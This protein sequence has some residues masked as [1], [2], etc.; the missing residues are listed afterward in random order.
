MSIYLYSMEYD[1]ESVFCHDMES[2]FYQLALEEEYKQHQ[3]MLCLPDEICI[4]VFSYCDL[5]EIEEEQLFA[6]FMKQCTMFKTICVRFSKILTHTVI[7]DLY[8]GYSLASKNKALQKIT[9]TILQSNYETKIPGVLILLRS[10]ASADVGMYTK[11]RDAIEIKYS[12]FS[13][14]HKAL[15]YKALIQKN[16]PLLKLLL[17]YGANPNQL[18]PDKQPLFFLSPTIDII[19]LFFKKGADLN[20]KD[21]HGNNVLWHVQQLPLELVQFY[22]DHKVDTRYINPSNKTCILH[23]LAPSVKYINNSNDLFK[24][25]VLLIKTIPDM[26]N[27]LDAEGRTPIDLMEKKLEMEF[28]NNNPRYPFKRLIDFYRISGGKNA[29]ELST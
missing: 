14:L 12:N 9:R 27:T 25:G 4:H 21:K 22:I 24:K 17:D 19:N 11:Y 20:A 18:H 28:Y 7:G 13:L 16:D 10:G 6:A 26:V 15:M 5:Q 23:A 2:I 3:L 8:K 29:Q 1:M